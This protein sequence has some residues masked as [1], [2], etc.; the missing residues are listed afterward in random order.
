MSGTFCCILIVMESNRRTSSIV[1]SN[2][3]FKRIENVCWACLTSTQYTVL[4]TIATLNSIGHDAF[5]GMAWLL[6][7]EFSR[8][9]QKKD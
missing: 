2:T 9:S 6:V 1:E 7:F 4:V 3:R 8:V 5:N